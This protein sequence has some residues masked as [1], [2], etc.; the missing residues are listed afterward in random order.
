MQVLNGI[1]ER[2]EEEEEDDDD[3]VSHALHSSTVKFFSARISQLVRK[4]WS[5]PMVSLEQKG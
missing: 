4:L 1:V 2:E 5:E 3:L